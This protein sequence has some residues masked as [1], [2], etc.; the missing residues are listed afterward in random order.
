MG[1][2][3]VAL[4]QPKD[5]GMA[6]RAAHPEPSPVEEEDSGRKGAKSDDEAHDGDS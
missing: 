3:P 2:G 6:I 4:P 5:D 1:A